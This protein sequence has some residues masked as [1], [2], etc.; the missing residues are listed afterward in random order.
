MKIICGIAIFCLWLVIVGG[1]VFA[2]FFSFCAMC[3]LGFSWELALGDRILGGI[4]FFI[5]LSLTFLAICLP[6]QFSKFLR[7]DDLF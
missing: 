3:N 2:T 7:G 4:F 6:W 5:G 1:C